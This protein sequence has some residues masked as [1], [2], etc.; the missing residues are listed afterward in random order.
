[1]DVITCDREASNCVESVFPTPALEAMHANEAASPAAA[2][3]KRLRSFLRPAS[4][5]RK[6]RR[7]SKNL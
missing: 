1:M 4:A 7:R 3:E 5:G 2:M 6:R